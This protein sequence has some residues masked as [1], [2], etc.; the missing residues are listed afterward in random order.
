MNFASAVPV[1]PILA[2]AVAAPP[3][4]A[5]GVSKAIPVTA[6]KAWDGDRHRL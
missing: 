4:M 1:A 6:E 2:P 5:D 3:A